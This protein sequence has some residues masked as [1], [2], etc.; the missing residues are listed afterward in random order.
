[1]GLLRSELDDRGI[2]RH[3]DSGIMIMY[4][5][6]KPLWRAHEKVVAIHLL[7]DDQWLVVSLRDVDSAIDVWRLA[8]T[9]NNDAALVLFLK[10]L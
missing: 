2:A 5:S 4:V 9:Q 3:T 1:M 7:A 8:I 10:R 6:R